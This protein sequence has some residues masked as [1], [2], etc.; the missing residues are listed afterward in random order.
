MLGQPRY[1]ENPRYVIR[2]GQVS[3]LKIRLRQTLDSGTPLNA[4]IFPDMPS[5][6]SQQRCIGSTGPYASYIAGVTSSP[7]KLR[8]SPEGYVL[9][10]SGAAL[11]EADGSSKGVAFELVILSDHPVDVASMPG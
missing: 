11:S 6:A 7:V 4:A 9:I 8:P 10:V 5:A 1:A 3:L 2:P